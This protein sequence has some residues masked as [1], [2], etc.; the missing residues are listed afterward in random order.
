MQLVERHRQRSEATFS[1]CVPQHNRTSFLIAAIRIACAQKFKDFEFCISDGCS[2]DG[3]EEELIGVLEETGFPF[4]YQRHEINLPYDKNTRSAIEMAAGRYCILMGND[5]ALNG[6]DAFERLFSD[7]Q[8][9]HFPGVIISDF[10][11]FRTGCRAYRIREFSNYGAG[12]QVAAMHYRNF[13]FVSGITLDRRAAQKFSTEAWD[14]SEM[15]Q[16]FVGCRMIASGL[17]LLERDHQL[18]RKD[19]I[20]PGESV[21]T[22]ATKPRVYPCPVTTRRLPL[23]ELAKLVSD[24]IEPYTTPDLLRRLNLRIA[25][26]LLGITYPIWLFQYRRVQSWKYAAGVALGMRPSLTATM[27]LSFIGKLATWLTFVTT[28]LGG[29]VIPPRIF[30]WVHGPLYF[31]AKLIR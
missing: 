30:T 2:T 28:S 10:C 22:F 18:V 1:I 25:L 15:Y 29:L 8:S 27:P 5:D 3:R 9:Q 31:I 7:I 16:T 17:C 6:E 14:G 21:E 12:P 11:D 19:I 13:S 4:A 23:G 26:Q 20:L 24:A